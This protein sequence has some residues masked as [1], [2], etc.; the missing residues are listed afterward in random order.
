MV[1]KKLTMVFLPLSFG[2]QFID[3]PDAD[4]FK[5]WLGNFE[6]SILTKH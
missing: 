2:N 5:A 4:P 6:V 3:V 1:A